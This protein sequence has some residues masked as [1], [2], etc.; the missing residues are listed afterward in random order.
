M[1]DRIYINGIYVREKEGKYGPF[2][3]VSIDVQKLVEQAKQHG[4]GKFLNVTISALRQKKDNGISHSVALDTYKRDN[5]RRGFAEAKQAAS[6][7]PKQGRFDDVPGA[8]P[9]DDSD[10]VPF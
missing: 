8:T 1:N 10:P 5:D 6:G 4:D 3:S 2:F 7:E 9:P